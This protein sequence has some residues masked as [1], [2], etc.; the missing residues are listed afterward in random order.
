MSFLITRYLDKGVFDLTDSFLKHLM[1]IKFAKND[2]FPLRILMN[3]NSRPKLLRI[4]QK[5]PD[6]ME[7]VSDIKVS[8]FFET[9]LLEDKEEEFFQNLKGGN[10]LGNEIFENVASGKAN[11]SRTHTKC[12]L[13]DELEPEHEDL[14]SSPG[15]EG[16][17]WLKIFRRENSLGENSPKYELFKRLRKKKH[18]GSQDS[19]LDLEK[20]T[21]KDLFQ[22][23]NQSL[24]ND[25]LTYD[26]FLEYLAYLG[27][28][29]GIFEN[30]SQS[31]YNPKKCGE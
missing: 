4:M 12:K 20:T 8:G 22:I 31:Y 19:V 18:S 5:F 14:F 27:L 11:R 23:P 29:E 2:Q 24:E 7:L 6:M 9:E 1:D 3:L 13:E 10:T 30:I 28:P 16:K 15:T 25:S 26:V 17:S 21:E